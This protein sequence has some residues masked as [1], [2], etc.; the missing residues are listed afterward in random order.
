MIS[1]CRLLKPHSLLLF[2]TGSALVLDRLTKKIV[3]QAVPLFANIQIL[4]ES[5]RITHVRNTGI[6]FGLFAG[7]ENSLV[8]VLLLLLSLLA[9]GVVLHLYR[10]SDKSR[11]EQVAMGLIMGGAF[12]NL[13]DRFFHRYV[14]DFIDI[15]TAAFRWY[16]FN[17]AD[18]FIF[19]GLFVWALRAWMKEKPITEV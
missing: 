18:V 2:C 3:E 11:M 13:F 7:M 17:L 10:I 6:A 8:R 12:G 19:T 15:G 1:F 14:T 5:F 16:T 9:L 4:G